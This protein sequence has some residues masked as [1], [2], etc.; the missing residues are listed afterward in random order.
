MAAAAIAQPVIDIMFG[1]AVG[2]S[3]MAD[4]MMKF[5]GF[6]KSKMAAGGYLGYTKMATTLLPA[7]QSILILAWAFQERQI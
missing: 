7:C 1:S 5:S 4:P 3:E 2:F 6:Q